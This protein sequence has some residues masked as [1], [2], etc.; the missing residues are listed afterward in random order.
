MQNKLNN[1]LFAKHVKCK[2]VTQ[3][4]VWH[5]TMQDTKEISSKWWNLAKQVPKT[6]DRALWGWG[7]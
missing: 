4:M 6:F 1:V 5:K 3:N 7:I 2:K